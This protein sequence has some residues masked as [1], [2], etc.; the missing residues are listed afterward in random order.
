MT[1]KPSALTSHLGLEGPVQRLAV[2]L[3]KANT[4]LEGQ[5]QPQA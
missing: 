5:S 2:S 3:T 4:D 1:P